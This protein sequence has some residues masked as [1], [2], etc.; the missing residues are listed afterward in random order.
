MYVAII[1][2]QMIATT[3]QLLLMIS[4]LIHLTWLNHTLSGGS[5]LTSNLPPLISGSRTFSL[6]PTAIYGSR[7]CYKYSLY[8]SFKTF[9]YIYGCSFEYVASIVQIVVA[10]VHIHI[11]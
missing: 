10:L 7:M 8:A 1:T 11:A 5:M 9:Q 3:F 4:N 6:Y 2:F